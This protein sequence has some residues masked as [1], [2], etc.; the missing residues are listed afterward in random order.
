MNRYYGLYQSWS[1][2]SSFT[3][4]KD[5]DT[6]RHRS[7]SVLLRIRTGHSFPSI[8]AHPLATSRVIPVAL[9]RTNFSLSWMCPPPPSTIRSLPRLI[10]IYFPIGLAKFHLVRPIPIYPTIHWLEAYSLLWWWRQYAPL[11]RRS[12]STTL[13]GAIFQKVVIF[14]TKLPVKTTKISSL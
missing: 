8:L 1:W 10:V 12:T 11:K 14:N 4:S 3:L 7:P 5:V 9:K 6:P 2:K 13:Q